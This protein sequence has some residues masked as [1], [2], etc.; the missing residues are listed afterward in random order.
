MTQTIFSV[1][2]MKNI[3]QKKLSQQDT[4]EVDQLFYGVHFRTRELL[5]HEVKG[6]QTVASYIDMLRKA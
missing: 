4:L 5:S 6:C 1:T 2:G 3:S